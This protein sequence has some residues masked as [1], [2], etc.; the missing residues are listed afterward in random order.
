MSTISIHAGGFT[1]ASLGHQEA[2]TQLGRLSNSWFTPLGNLSRNGLFHLVFV[3]AWVVTS[4]QHP[5]QES[6]D[7]PPSTG[8]SYTTAP[9]SYLQLTILCLILHLLNLHSSPQVRVVILNI[10]FDIHFS[11]P[12]SS[13]EDGRP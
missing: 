13:K 11:C 5:T 8:P 10:Y 7:L 9:A 4:R 12:N 6:A 2:S 3:R 1:K